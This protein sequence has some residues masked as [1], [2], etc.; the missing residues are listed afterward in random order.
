MTPETAVRGIEAFYRLLE[1]ENKMCG[2]SG[3]SSDYGI[4][5]STLDCFK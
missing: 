1:H 5:L 4:D 2:V 3:R